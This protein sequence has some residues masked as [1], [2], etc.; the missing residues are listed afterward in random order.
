V[1]I[2]YHASHELYSP[3]DL[4]RLVRRAEELGFP[5][6]MCSD[7][8]HPWTPEQGESGYAWAWLG[9]ALQATRLPF[10]VVC[11]P[12]QRYHPAIVAQK[13]ATLAQMFPERFWIAVGTGQNLNEHVTGDPWPAKPARRERLTE[14]VAVM[15]DLWAGDTVS[16]TGR[17]V[18]VEAAKLY[19][20]PEVPPRLIGAAITA[21][22]ARWVGGWA[23]GLITVGKDADGLREV[24]D[25]FRQGGGAGKPVY[26]QAAVSWARTEAEAVA[27]AKRNWPIAVVDLTQNQDLA[28]PEAFAAACA[29]ATE[30]DLRKDLRISADLERHRDWL[31]SD[32][33]LGIDGV[34]LHPIGPDPE[35]FLDTFAA[36]VLPEFRG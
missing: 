15:R 21:E 23:D 16:R 4:L 27:A 10:G 20:L 25:A 14:A 19:S 5:A 36:E 17:H 32:R 1:Q 28:T 22:T 8:F 6:A 3:R 26:L 2:G 11:A 30:E 33:E 29:G 12:G 18:R 7:H 13:A 31:R 34:Y 24:I 9:A 35:R